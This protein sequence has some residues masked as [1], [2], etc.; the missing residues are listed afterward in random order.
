MKPVIKNHESRHGYSLYSP[1]HEKYYN[2]VLDTGHSVILNDTP[3]WL[4]F[5]LEE[6]DSRM[7]ERD[8]LKMMC[9]GIIELFEMVLVMG[10]VG[11]RASFNSTRLVPMIRKEIK[12]NFGLDYMIVCIPD[13]SGSIPLT[14]VIRE[15]DIDFVIHNESV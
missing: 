8:M 11:T 6:L 1:E 4:M 15:F 9:R 5:T 13:H 3:D 12:F 10:V 2:Y 14:T 7:P